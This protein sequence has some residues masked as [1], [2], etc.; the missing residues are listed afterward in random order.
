[1]DKDTPTTTFKEA[2]HPLN[3]TKVLEDFL[4]VNRYVKKLTYEKLVTLMMGLHQ[5]L[6][7][8]NTDKYG[9]ELK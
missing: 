4:G 8:K 1:M 6:W 7:L 3:I 5:N 2:L 9:N